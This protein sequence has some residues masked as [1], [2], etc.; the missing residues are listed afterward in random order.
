[1]A[2]RQTAIGAFVLGGIVLG[3][4]TIVLFG[5][6]RLWSPATRAA[7]V[8][9]G[10]VSGLSV[11][12]PV[13]FRGV[14]VG[15]VSGI[16]IQYDAR[17]QTV[18]IPV[19][20]QLDSG[21][22]RVSDETAGQPVVDLPNLIARGL[23]AELNTQSFVTGQSVINLD[24]NPAAP[25]VLHPGASALVEIPTQQS[26][27]QRVTQQLSDLPLR[28]LA[29]SAIATLESVR[30]LS[31]RLDSDLPPAIASI[32]AT[33][34]GATHMTDTATQ[35]IVGVQEKLATAL[36][37]IT[38]LAVNA[39]RRLGERSGDL[40]VLLGSANQTVVQ[41]RDALR[42]LKGL[43]SDRGAARINL[44]ATLRDL[45]ATAA[46]LRGFASDVERN[47]QLLLTGRR[48]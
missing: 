36:D 18:L 26:T 41:A 31:D 35:A 33:S 43:T 45:A 13:T 5:N 46:S 11:G 42:D 34:E 30:K 21:R 8:F 17:T 39:D 47:P 14:R 48:P 12:A 2:D 24:F 9:E 19:T 32:K 29:E 4:G 44:E 40:R 25:A 6:L 1:M 27:I 10:S 20:L 15:A 23:R 3:L 16:V 22:V 7:V 38:Q 37:H 28:E